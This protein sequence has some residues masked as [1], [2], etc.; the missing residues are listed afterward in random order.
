MAA[1][2]SEPTHDVIVIGG[3]PVG[4]NAAQYAIQGSDR[5]AALV[6]AELV[7]G[8]CSYWACMPSKALLVPAAV[9]SLAQHMPGLGEQAPL[10]VDAVLAR[11][12]AFTSGWDD[13]GQV[14][15]AEGVGIEV[16]RGRARLAGERTVVV[17]DRTLVARHA[18]VLA[19]GSVPAEPPIDGLADALPWGSRDATAMHEVPGSILVVGGGVVA[20]EAATWLAALGAHVTLAARGGLLARLEPEAAAAVE[21]GLRDAG[22]DVRLHAD[23]QRV[24]REAPAATGTGHVHGGAVTT[25]IDG[26]DVTTDE[27][28]VATGRRPATGDLG[29]ETVGLDAVAVDGRQRVAGVD[30]WLYAAGDVAG[31]WQ[32]THMGK[33]E[34]RIAGEVIG[35]IADGGHAH[36]VVGVDEDPLTQVV[37]TD[38]EVA[39][40][41]ITQAEAED[42]GIRVERV[43]IDLAVAGTSLARDDAGGTVIAIVDAD[44]DVLVGV[45]LVG[46]GVAE[47]LHA[48][49]VAVAARV[50]IPRLWH[51]V[52]AYPT[53]S[54]IWLRVVEDLRR[55]RRAD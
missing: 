9:R 4:E 28:L 7:G 6:E 25:T 35:R 8:E 10:D 32:L 40:V 49:T 54:E 17:G 52:P 41:G 37:F 12:D 31:R 16:V 20:C 44:R 14:A 43:A 42:A 3:G 21:Q 1:S 26:V 48:A 34:A 36:D 51:A 30:G 39:A 18:V 22:V 38:P 29:L 55:Q 19:T 15:W 27:I 53:A 11:R 24:R 13:A 23:V 46:H 45:T 33:H 2:A 50:P 47:L 5:T